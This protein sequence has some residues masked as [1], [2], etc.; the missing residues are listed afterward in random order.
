MTRAD[1]ILIVVVLAG[2]GVLYQQLW[3]PSEPARI[4]HVHVGGEWVQST[5]LDG[6]RELRIEGA[7]GESVLAVRPGGIRFIAS[8]CTQKYCVHS[9]W[10]TRGGEFAACVPNQV[11]VH[12]EGGRER[13]DAINF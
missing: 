6:H 10:Q 4:A 2:L 11:S 5:P 7:L 12:V 13:F 1:L 3:R 9:G 8:A